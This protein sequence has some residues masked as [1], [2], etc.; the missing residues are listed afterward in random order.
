MAAGVLAVCS[1][2]S[3]PDGTRLAECSAL[4]CG[5]G[6]GASSLGFLVGKPTP[7]SQYYWDQVLSGRL[8]KARVVPFWV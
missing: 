2:Y 5:L 7:V 1:V 6:W 3:G 8:A 4:L